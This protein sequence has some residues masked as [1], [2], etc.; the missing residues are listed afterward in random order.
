MREILLHLKNVRDKFVEAS[1]GIKLKM[2]ADIIYELHNDAGWRDPF[3]HIQEKPAWTM[4]QVKGGIKLSEKA[5]IVYQS[6]TGLFETIN[7][8]GE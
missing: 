3:K 1:D 2:L 4:L 6:P 8:V 7:I 5:A